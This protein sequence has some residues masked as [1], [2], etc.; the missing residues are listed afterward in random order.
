M[1]SEVTTD[2]IISGIYSVFDVAGQSVYPVV[3]LAATSDLA[4]RTF[5]N[6]VKGE[7]SIFGKFPSDFKLIHLAD[8]D[9][10]S[11]EVV[12]FLCAVD[13]I[14]ADAFFTPEQLADISKSNFGIPSLNTPIESVTFK[15]SK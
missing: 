4:I 3:F 1:V 9:L 14:H 13:V 6:Y 2:N 15:S 7:G 8:V 12:S 5:S 11:G 10:S